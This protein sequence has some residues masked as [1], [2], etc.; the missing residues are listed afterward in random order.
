M[1]ASSN[2]FLSSFSSLITHEYFSKLKTRCTKIRYW[3]IVITSL[4]VK[5]LKQSVVDKKIDEKEALDLK[6]IY[7]LYLDKR[8]E[9]MKSTGSKVQ[10]VFGDFF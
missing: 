8:K 3:I 9:M 6:K 2:T 4:Y 10:D 7:N 5:T 1:C